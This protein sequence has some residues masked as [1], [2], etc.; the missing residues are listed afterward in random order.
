MI[1]IELLRHGHPE[2]G[3]GGIAD[4][5]PELSELGKAQA[6]RAAESLAKRRFDH[7]FVSPLTRALQTARPVSD[8]LGIQ[9]QVLPWL[10]ELGHPRFA[11]ERMDKVDA[12]FRQATLR[13]PEAWWDG[14]PGGA[15]FRAFAE[16]VQTGMAQLLAGLGIV[17][18]DSSGHQLWKSQDQELRLLFVAHVGTGGVML[19]HLLNTAVVPWIY[20]RF[21]LGYAGLWGVETAPLADGLV[22]S[23]RSFNDQTHLHGLPEPPG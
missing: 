3:P 6:E 8:R 12:F 15:S 17:S 11:G 23:L 21:N 19:S 22:W 5:D 7:V 10:A 1:V 18:Y 14:L 4:D 9:P 16:W 2:W 20:T 13:P